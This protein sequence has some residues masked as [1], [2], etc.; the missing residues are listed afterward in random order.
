MKSFK[1]FFSTLIGL[2]LIAHTHL[3]MAGVTWRSYS[4]SAFSTALSQNKLVLV[5]IKTASCHWCSKMNSE[6]FQS[7]AVVSLINRKFIPV[8]I[9]MGDQPALSRTFGARGT[10]TFVILNGNKRELS[11]EVGYQT[12]GEFKS[13]LSRF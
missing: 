7:P 10:P 8:S 5:Y 13:F 11:R 9:D 6:A 3:A 4:N 12:S 1:I 2:L